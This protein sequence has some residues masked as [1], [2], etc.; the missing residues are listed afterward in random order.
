MDHL[1]KLPVTLKTRITVP[2]SLAVAIRVPD[3]ENWIAASCPEWAGIIEVDAYKV[4]WPQKSKW[5]K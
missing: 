5:L 3:G 4:I 1:L 2:L